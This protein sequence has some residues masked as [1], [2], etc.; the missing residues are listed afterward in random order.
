VAENGRTWTKEAEPERRLGEEHGEDA[1][2]VGLLASRT[3]CEFGKTELEVELGVEH[4]HAKQEHAGMRDGLQSYS[5]TQG[6]RWW[7]S[8][9]QVLRR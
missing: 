1:Q 5:S 3:C 7:Q 4:G 6:T 2:G 8:F 9:I